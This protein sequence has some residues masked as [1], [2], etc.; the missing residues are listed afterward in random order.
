MALRSRHHRYCQTEQNQGRGVSE[1]GINSPF[2]Q[3][4]KSSQ[5]LLFTVGPA[6]C[7]LLQRHSQSQIR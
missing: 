1:T 6:A 3:V 2:Q 4:A 5:G 7:R